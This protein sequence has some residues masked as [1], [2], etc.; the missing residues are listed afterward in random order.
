MKITD[1]QKEKE[2]LLLQNRFETAIAGASRIIT[3]E[4]IEKCFKQALEKEGWA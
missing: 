4:E 1:E 3:K 2:L